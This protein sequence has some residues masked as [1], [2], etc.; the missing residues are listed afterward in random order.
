MLLTLRAA[1]GAGS[2]LWY[3]GALHERVRRL[4]STPGL[5]G[6]GAVLQ[7]LLEPRSHADCFPPSSLLDSSGRIESIPPPDEKDLRLSRVIG[8]DIQ[9][10]VLDQAVQ[11]TS[12]VAGDKERWTDLTL[13]LYEGSLDVH[14]DSFEGVHAIIATEVIEHL[15]PVSLLHHSTVVHIRTSYT[16]SLQG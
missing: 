8:L 12:P 7:V 13:E 14:N 1:A 6:E 10:E 16:Y 3:V 5:L 4:I 11:F 2:R 15:F 9:R